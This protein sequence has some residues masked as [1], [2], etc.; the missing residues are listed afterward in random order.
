MKIYY[1]AMTRMTKREIKE[2]PMSELSAIKEAI[3]RYF[4][5]PPDDEH[6]DKI[7]KIGNEIRTECRRRIIESEE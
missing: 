7:E 6:W 1:P 3:N 2:L 4:I 5:F